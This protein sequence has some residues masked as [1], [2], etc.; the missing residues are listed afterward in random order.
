M[1]NDILKP[2]VFLGSNSNI[3]KIYELCTSVGYNVVGIID[4]DYHRHGKF[5]ELNVI[6]SEQELIDNKD[7]LQE[8]YQYICVTNWYTNDDTVCNYDIISRNRE[9]RNKLIDLL[10]NLKLEIATVISPLAKVSKYS[11]IGKGIFVDDFAII[12]PSVTIADHNS[13]Y[14][15]S[16]IGHDSIINRNCV[17]QRYCFITS[18][19]TIENNVYMG[20][21]SRILRSKAIISQGTFIHPGLTLLRS[22]SVNE[23]ISLVGKDLRKVYQNVEIE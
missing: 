4:D 16:Y 13:I 11:N 20:L 19:V 3:Y 15:F 12:E 21:C 7:N 2:L 23:E 18:T 9:K 22:T 14:A 6:A 5:K 10:D 8:K 1:I 17:I